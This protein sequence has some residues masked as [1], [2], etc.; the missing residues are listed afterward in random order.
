VLVIVLMLV[1]DWV[2][3]DYEHEREEPEFAYFELRR[4]MFAA[5][6]G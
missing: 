2:D 1:L 5:Y 3:H 4:S 6:L